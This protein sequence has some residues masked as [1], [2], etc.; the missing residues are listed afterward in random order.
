M[1]MCRTVLLLAVVTVGLPEP[2]VSQGAAKAIPAPV[3]VA[4]A[5]TIPA[6][7]LFVDAAAASG[8]AGSDAKPFKT[9]AAAVAAASSG[10]VICVAE[11]T[12]A[13]TIEAVEKAFTLAGGFQKGAGFKVRDSAKYVS[14]AVGK[15]EGSFLRIGGDVAPPADSLSAVDGF[16]ITGYSQAVVRD[17]WEPQRFDLTNNHIH[18]NTCKGEGISGAAFALI[19]TSGTVSGNVI[20]NNTCWRGGGG[21]LVDNLG[22]GIV[23]VSN[24]W[25]EGNSGV[26]P[27]SGHGGAFYFFVKTLTVTGNLFLN[28]SVTGWGAGLY[29]GAFT[30]GGQITNATMRWN[31]YRGNKAGDSGGGFFCD[32]GAS[33]VS[34]HEVYDGNCGG[35]VLVDGG[36]EGSDPTR[37]T[38]NF[39]TSVGALKPGCDGPGHG[40]YVDTYEAVARD[41]YS[42]SNALFWGNGED[43]AVSCDKKCNELSVSIDYAMLKQ[44][45]GIGIKVKYGAHLVASA[46]P[47][48][49]DAAKGDFRL[50]PG[51]P[52]IGRGTPQGADL[53][54]FAKDAVA[55]VAAE[56][57]SVPK[58]ASSAPVP[59]VDEAVV[60]KPVEVA[61]A[62]TAAAA[63]GAD[64]A[65]IKQAFDDA[66]ALGTIA[67]WRAFLHNF[68]EGY[69]ADLA[70]AYLRNLGWEPGSG[71]SAP[72]GSAAT[73][74][75]KPSAAPPPAPAAQPA[76]T[77]AASPPQPAAQQKPA[78]PVVAV[79][80]APAVKRGAKFFAFPEKF[81]RYYTDPGWVSLKTIFA[82]PVGSGDGGTR[83]APMA[84]ADAVAAAKPGSKIVMLPGAYKG[85]IEFTKETGGTYDAPIVIYG[86]RNVDGS[87]GVKV[88]CAVGE[89]KTCFNFEDASYVAV[90]GVE[91]LGGTYGVRAVGLGFARSEH[92]MGIAALN[93]VGR[94]QDRDPFKTAQA[95][96]SVIEGNVGTGAKKGDGHGI[97]ISGGSDWG[98]VRFNNTHSNASSDLQINADPASNCQE[99][100][101]PFADPKCDAYAGDGEGGQGASDYF[102]VEGNYSHHS[103]V[104]P[105][106]TSVRRS[107]IRNN[108]FGPQ[109]RHNASFWQET[110]NPKLGSSENRI[111]HN[112]FITTNKRHAVKF[113]TNASRNIFAGNLVLG[114]SI[115]GGKVGANPGA[116]LMETDE[117]SGDNTAQGN[118][119][120]GGGIFEGREPGAGETV[121]K[122]FQPT[123]FA[124]F[125][126]TSAEAFSGFTPQAGAPFLDKSKRSADVPVDM[127]G[128]VRKDPSDA[129]PIEAP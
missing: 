86:E 95:D 106:F 6:C 75:P 5:T 37:A 43:L 70:G 110:D 72:A 38:F 89:R 23:I 46:D 16:E 1:T 15:G 71:Q 34:E 88:D 119:Y 111:L 27:E 42:I 98:I 35:N 116:L 103:D 113:S 7:S 122:D 129:G 63:G 48:F 94:D 8:G 74:P 45:E 79:Q 118:V 33:C 25:V 100:G 10:A 67:A 69:Y 20:R 19:S 107:V 65:K 123:W 36:S 26:E 62:P 64:D 121:V 115:E 104:G 128:V 31:V 57:V 44:S 83:E 14:K 21:A 73:A 85:G 13:E 93:S 54:A 49:V 125:P 18:D 68:P 30:P 47:Q 124:A 102:L 109:T 108:I 39:I 126:K 92:S 28:N 40:F 78:A 2:G 81:N 114:V 11:G 59:K 90:D 120:L 60:K 77:A 52:A 99:V 87:L 84:M 3:S 58:A 96:W 56:A 24:N 105:N 9:I 101:V 17:F 117:T 127:M 29:V 80:R 51:S 91:M 61:D 12:Y 76:P 53:G 112:L 55:P 66:K 4:R 32:D 82:A 97:Y 22:K 41:T 50:K